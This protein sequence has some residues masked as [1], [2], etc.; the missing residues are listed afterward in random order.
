MTPYQ[1]LIA[2]FDDLIIEHFMNTNNETFGWRQA[3][4]HIAEGKRVD[5]CVE[6]RGSTPIV[7]KEVGEELH[8]AMIPTHKT[9]M[10]RLHPEPRKPLEIRVKVHTR[11]D[12]TKHI[13]LIEG[14]YPDANEVLFREVIEEEGR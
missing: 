9:T 12:G 1:R 7:W 8:H 11:P 10:Y 13:P 5:C 4:K 6:R 14:Y 2:Q 3:C